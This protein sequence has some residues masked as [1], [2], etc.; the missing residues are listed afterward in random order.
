M[1]ALRKPCCVLPG[2]TALNFSNTA[3]SLVF[4]LISGCASAR[5]HRGVPVDRG[6]GPVDVPICLTRLEHADGVDHS[7]VQLMLKESLELPSGPV[8]IDVR[9]CDRMMPAGHTF[10]L[11]FVAQKGAEY[12]VAAT[13]AISG[14]GGPEGG[15][16]LC[17]V[18]VKDAATSTILDEASLVNPHD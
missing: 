1:S 15:S 16:D 9:L 5:L 11:A 8:E 4:A 10:T 17:E 3:I 13:C 12:E 18:I 14:M 7:V 6:Y 2:P